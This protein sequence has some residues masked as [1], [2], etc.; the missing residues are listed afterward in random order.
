MFMPSTGSRPKYGFR[1]RFIKTDADT[2]FAQ[3]VSFPRN[4]DDSAA[5]FLARVI[6]YS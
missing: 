3:R 6:D 5:D 2:F 1:P 4:R